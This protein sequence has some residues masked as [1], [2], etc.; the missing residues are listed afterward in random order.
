[1]DIKIKTFLDEETSSYQ[2][3]MLG[4]IENNIIIYEEENINVA[5]IIESDKITLTRKT[6]DYQLELLFD[7]NNETEGSYFINEINQNIKLNIKT[8]LLKFVDNKLE[9]RYSV[10]TKEG[11]SYFRLEYEVLKWNKS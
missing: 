2:G 1:M 3:Y 6:S 8:S 11:E 5:I 9:I 4:K 10:N 7:L